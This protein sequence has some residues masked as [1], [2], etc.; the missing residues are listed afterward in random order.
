MERQ[1]SFNLQTFIDVRQVAM[2]L[3]ACDEQ[4]V[5]AC[6]A[7]ELGKHCISAVAATSK[8]QIDS[9]QLALDIIKEHGFSVRQLA[10]RG[11]GIRRELVLEDSNQR[12]AEFDK[13]ASEIASFIEK[14]AENGENGRM[15]VPH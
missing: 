8:A 7:S 6:S 11:D 2:A 13:R 12:S 3:L 1:A 5:K 9:V 10:R 15:E 4:G 14:G